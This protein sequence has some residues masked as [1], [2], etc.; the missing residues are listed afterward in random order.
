MKALS[1]REQQAVVSQWGSLVNVLAEVQGVLARSD[2][3]VAQRLVAVGEKVDR[4]T[5]F[6]LTHPWQDGVEDRKC[7]KSR[8]GRRCGMIKGH[9][10]QHIAWGD[11]P[12]MTLRWI[13][14]RA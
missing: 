5:D 11:T 8:D 1:E 6:M 12:E 7:E 10:P 4:M 13:D 2:F 9:G 3:T 14:G